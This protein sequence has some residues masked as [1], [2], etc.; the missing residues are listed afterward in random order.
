MGA[1]DTLFGFLLRLMKGRTV[2]TIAHRLSTIRNADMIAV[3]GES[4][5][6]ETGSYDQLMA[7]PDG[8]FRKLVE[9]Q[10]IEK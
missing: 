6:L 2:F 7:M 1:D 3:L 9:H 8:P 10:T 4:R 5:L